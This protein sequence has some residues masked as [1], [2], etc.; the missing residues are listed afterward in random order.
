MLQKAVTSC[1]APP[2]VAFVSATS[3]KI[4]CTDRLSPEAGLFNFSGSDTVH[5][6]Q[7]D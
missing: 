4:D 5:E 2:A 6:S 3:F 7:F 1:M